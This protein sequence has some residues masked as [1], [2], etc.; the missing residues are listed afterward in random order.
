MLSKRR[1]TQLVKDGHVDGWD[2]PRMLTLSG[3]RRRGIPAVAVRDFVSRLGVTKSD[4]VVDPA[5][6]DHCV[7]EYLNK[8]AGAPDGGDSPAEGGD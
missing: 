4:S 6:L 3:L 7:R 5:L 8:V 1:L 2:D